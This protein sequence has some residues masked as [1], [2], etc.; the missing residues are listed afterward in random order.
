M[1]DIDVQG[2]A[3]LR[4]SLLRLDPRH[5]IR[6]GF[7]DIFISPP[8]F[9]VLETRLRG[10]G[11][12]DEKVIK[13]RLANAKAEMDRASEYTHKVLNDDLETAYGE[14]RQIILTAMGLA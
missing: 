14:F 8:S 10:R 12:D 9:E 1:L 5:P 11:T 3:Q 13:K 7:M 2:A 6:R 4:D